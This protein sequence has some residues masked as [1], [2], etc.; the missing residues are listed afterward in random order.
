MKQ[1]TQELFGG[2][3]EVL[4]VLKGAKEKTWKGIDVTPKEVEKGAYNSS[5][6]TDYKNFCI[7]IDEVVSADGNVTYFL[8]IKKEKETLI[9]QGFR[10][11]ILEGKYLAKYVQSLMDKLKVQEEFE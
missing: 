7:V 5:F 2:D 8:G 6:F 9:D 4:K 3:K 1:L 11:N 10:E